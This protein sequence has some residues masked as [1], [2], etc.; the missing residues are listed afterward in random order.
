M[1]LN[2]AWNWQVATFWVGCF[3]MMVN[4]LTAATN[5]QIFEKQKVIRMRL[6]DLEQ[7]IATLVDTQGSHTMPPQAQKEPQ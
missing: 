2:F 4:L 1:K 3:V 6:A 7:K 5:W